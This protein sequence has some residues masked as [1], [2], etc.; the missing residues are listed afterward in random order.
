MQTKIRVRLICLALLGVGVWESLH[1]PD[2][3]AES[4]QIERLDAAKVGSL[5]KQDGVFIFFD[6]TCPICAEYFPTI[7]RLIARFGQVKFS[8]V[9]CAVDSD[10]I[11]EFVRDYKPRCRILS[12]VDGSLRAALDAH[13][14]PEAVVKSAGKN[15]YSGRID[16]RYASIGHRRSVVGVHDL[17]NIL[18][19]ISNGQTVLPSKTAAVGCFIEPANSKS[20]AHSK[21]EN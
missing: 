2:A 19:T 10:R 3:L 9:F 16:D 17:E 7:E 8:L 18:A 6:P 14:T 15:V 21:K 12:D 11:A 4:T 1:S 13:V 5:A 20:L